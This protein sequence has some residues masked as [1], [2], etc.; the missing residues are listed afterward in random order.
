M[1][2]SRSPK[3]VAIV[4]LLVIAGVAAVLLTSGREP[5][6]SVSFTSLKG[7]TIDLQQWR[8]KVVLVNFWA[9]SCPGCVKEMPD[10]AKTYEAFHPRGFEMVAV[11]MSY[12]PPSYVLNYTTQNALP[13]PVALDTKGEIARAF[14]DVQLTPTTFLVDKEGRI[15]QRVLG[16]LDMKRLHEI[17]EKELST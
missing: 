2:L 12:D 3:I 16:E 9:T 4:A 5:A 6:P 13:F 17:L 8:G 1:S 15:I 14:G 7:E 10:L 11:A